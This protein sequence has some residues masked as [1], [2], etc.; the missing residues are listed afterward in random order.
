MFAAM[1]FL[2]ECL[3]SLDSPPLSDDAEKDGLPKNYFVAGRMVEV[4]RRV[5]F[6]LPER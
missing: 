6:M 4:A 5:S 1:E 2:E 3:V